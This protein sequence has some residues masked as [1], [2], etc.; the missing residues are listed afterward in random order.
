[1]LTDKGIQIKEQKVEWKVPCLNQEEEKPPSKKNR[2]CGGSNLMPII[3]GLLSSESWFEIKSTKEYQ[4]PGVFSEQED[5]SEP[6]ASQSLP[7]MGHVLNIQTL[8]HFTG[9]NHHLLYSEN[10]LSKGNYNDN[11]REVSINGEKQS[12]RIRYAACKGVLECSVAGCNFAGSK[13]AK[14]CP[15]H[16]TAEMTP[17][18]SCPVYIVYVYPQNHVENGERWITGITKDGMFNTAR[19]NLHNHPLPKPSKVPDIVHESVKHAVRCNPSITPGQLNLG[20][21]Y[22]AI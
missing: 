18:G 13:A 17:S 21:L 12:V 1:M 14:K 7:R 10:Q 11:L 16:P 2:T 9:E 20:N 22:C 15:N 3:E 8:P 5:T 4:Y 19:N 6:N